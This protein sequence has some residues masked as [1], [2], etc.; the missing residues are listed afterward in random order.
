MLFYFSL[1]LLL[2]VF[3]LEILTYVSRRTI[4]QE[5]I[6]PYRNHLGGT[7]QFYNVQNYTSLY[8]SYLGGTVQYYIV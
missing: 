6:S 4:V 3:F 2:Y 5:A 8:R 1:N 7:V